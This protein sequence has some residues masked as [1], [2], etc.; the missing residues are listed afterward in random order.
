MDILSIIIIVVLALVILLLAGMS[1]TYSHDSMMTA[2]NDARGRIRSERKARYSIGMVILS[3]GEGTGEV[4]WLRDM[5]SAYPG[6]RDERK[7]ADWEGRWLPRMRAYLDGIADGS[8]SHGDVDAFVGNESALADDRELLASTEASIA[9]M[10][11]SRVSMSLVTMFT[12]LSE[13][14]PAVRESVR[15]AR[16]RVARTTSSIDRQARERIGSVGARGGT[17]FR[18]YGN[19]RYFDDGDASADA[20]QATR[21][22]SGA[23]KADDA[24]Q[25]GGGSDEQ[26]ATRRQR[27]GTTAGG[28]GSRG[29]VASGSRGSWK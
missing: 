10:E 1:A 13:R 9:R 5:L 23:R 16:D 21:D 2:A 19:A 22:A 11:S 26:P 6:I 29:R 18:R 7:E 14:M 25:S 24:R 3:N 28:T 12:R 8:P 27:A 4:R 20:A 17:T 15:G